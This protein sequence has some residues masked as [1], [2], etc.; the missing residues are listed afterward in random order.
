MHTTGE[1]NY[2]HGAAQSSLFRN[3]KVLTRRD[4]DGSEQFGSDSL[5]LPLPGL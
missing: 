4:L 1:L 5:G 2:L 3:G